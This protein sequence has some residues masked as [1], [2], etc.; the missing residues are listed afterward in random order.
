LQAG[1]LADS[2]GPALSIGIGAF[3]SLLYGAFVAVRYPQ[4]RR[5]A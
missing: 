3:V 2:L 5:M 4:L 1:L